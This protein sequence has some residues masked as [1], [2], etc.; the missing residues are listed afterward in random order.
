LTDKPKRRYRV[1]RKRRSDWTDDATDVVGEFGCCLV[2]AVTASAI[3]IALVAV[4]L[5]LYS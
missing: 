5:T 4:P 2:E 3:I 1:R